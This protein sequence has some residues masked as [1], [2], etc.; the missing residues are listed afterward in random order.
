[1]F[2]VRTSFGG[3]SFPS[4]FY[5]LVYCSFGRNGKFFFSVKLLSS[6]TICKPDW[7]ATQLGFIIKKNLHITKE[8]KLTHDLEQITECVKVE[9]LE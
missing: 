7:S 9:L 1:M 2:T 4:K 5:N 8:Q 3:R 6:I